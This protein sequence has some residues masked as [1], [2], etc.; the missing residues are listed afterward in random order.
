MTE[1]GRFWC[2]VCQASFPDPLEDMHIEAHAQE[3]Q[4][5]LRLVPIFLLGALAGVIILVILIVRP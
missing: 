3:M 2:D 1:H 4:R 5:G